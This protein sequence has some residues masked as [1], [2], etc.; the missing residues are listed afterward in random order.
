MP[1][2]RVGWLAWYIKRFNTLK[3]GDPAIPFCAAQIA[4]FQLNIL[5]FG[6]RSYSPEKVKW[7]EPEQETQELETA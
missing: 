3:E 6:D 4:W 5:A 2:D 1:S 7:A